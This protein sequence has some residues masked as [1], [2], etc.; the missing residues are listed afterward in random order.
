M[1]N[2]RLNLLKDVVDTFVIVESKKTFTGKPKEL[3]FNENIENVI[4]IVVDFTST[5]AWENERMQRDS[6]TK[7][8][9]QLNLSDE[10]IILISD[11]DEIPDPVMLHKVKSGMLSITINA[12]ELDLFYYTL[13]NK[14]G[15]WIHSKILTFSEFKKKTPETIRHTICPVIPRSGWHLS[16]FG[17]AE[18]IANK[19]KNFS[20]Q[21][22]NNDSFTN[23]ESILERMK[24]NKDPFDRK[25]V[26]ISDSDYL[27][28][29]FS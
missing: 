25:I 1:V 8:V 21:E 29:N 3:Y 4:H 2:Y 22:F 20:H 27:P 15:V 26:G 19:I 10:D 11:V 17:D 9:E 23:L 7:G 18:F 13:K 16:Y 24:H 28:P 6:I 12:L 14:I 5:N